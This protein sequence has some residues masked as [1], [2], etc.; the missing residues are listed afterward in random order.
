MDDEQAQAI[1]QSIDKS[2]AVG[3]RDYAIVLL[4]Y[5]FGVRAGQV[6]ALQMEDIRWNMAQILFKASKN[7]KDCLLPLTD[8]VGD[9]LLSYIKE[10]RPSNACPEVFLTSRAP[11]HSIRRSSVISGMVHRY[12]TKAGIDL[13]TNGAHLFRHAFA[14]RMVQQGNS[15]KDVADVLGHR[16]LST[17]FIYA[18]VDFN[19]LQ[20]VALPWPQA[21]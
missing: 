19:A 9:S 4:L 14:S 2:T 5:T 13:P 18:K 10:A 17:T 3:K 8:E 15:L 20:Q 6:R 21:V 16:C 7:G 12:I 11:Y 1:L